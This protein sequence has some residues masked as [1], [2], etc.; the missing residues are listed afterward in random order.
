[1]ALV[2]RNRERERTDADWLAAGGPAP[3]PGIAVE[4]AKQC[5]RCGPHSAELAYQI[6]E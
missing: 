5:E 2:S 3:A 1:M 4:G 6:G